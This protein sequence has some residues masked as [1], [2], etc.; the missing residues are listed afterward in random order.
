MFTRSLLCLFTL[1]LFACPSDTTDPAD[2]TGD[3]PDAEMCIAGEKYD[4]D[5]GKCVP[6][7]VNPMD[8]S[9]MTGDTTPDAD[10]DMGPPCID[11]MLYIDEDGDGVGVDGDRN[12]TQ[13]V[14]FDEIVPGYARKFGDCDDTDRYRTPDRIELCDD[15]DNNCNDQVNEGITCEFYAQTG[16]ELYLID[17]F[18]KTATMLAAVPNLQDMDTH[19]NGKLYGVKRDG[20]FRFEPGTQNWIPIGEFTGMPSDPNGLAIDRDGT[21]FVTSENQLYRV[22]L[23]TG[24]ATLQGT[25]DNSVYSSGDCVINKGNSLF[26]TSK[27]RMNRERPDDLVLINAAQATTTILGSTRFNSIY[28]LTAAWGK[29]YGVTGDGEVIEL[30]EQTGVGTIIHKFDGLRFFGAASTPSR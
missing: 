4:E 23:E 28:G 18:K 30:N 3:M 9:D 25:L 29:L 26:M 24:T 1:F 14:T 27:D 20:L 15:I 7:F 10:M 8:M 5:Q 13:C 11:T 19:P 21:A 2:A 16:D 17:P 6:V 12:M 22:D